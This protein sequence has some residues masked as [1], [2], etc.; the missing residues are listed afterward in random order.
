M[1]NRNNRQ[2]Y[3]SI[4]LPF[5]EREIAPILP[6]KVLDFHTHTWSREGRM[7]GPR[8]SKLPGMKYMVTDEEY[9]PEALLADGRTCFPDREYHAVCFGY[10]TPT[11][12]WEKD[13]AFIAAA[14]TRRG[15]YPLVLAG[16]DLGRS[17][18]QYEQAIADGN[19]LGFK[20]VLNWLGDDYG[21]KRVEDLLGPREMKL[22]NERR[23]VVMLHV[24][25]AGRLADPV[26]QRGVQR[27]SKAYPDA[28]IVLAHCGRCYLPT[29]MRAAIE[30][31]RRLPNVRMDTAMVMDQTAIRMALDTIGPERLLYATD[32]PVAAMRG[33]RVAVMDHW[34]DVVLPGYPKSAYRVADGS[35]RATFMAWEIVLAIRWAAELAGLKRKELNGI[36][37]ENG[38]AILRR[39]DGGKALARLRKR[40]RQQEKS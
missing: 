8:Q 11:V 12:D 35:I 9:P 28:Q 19:F 32:F 23:L 36:F 37:F 34:V 31:I 21:N 6:P 16:K 13:T 30:S 10:P 39:V 14:G 7:I 17:R 40:W 24:P 33:R 4:D 26:V 15:L 25:R 5:Y 1:S 18:A 27:L 22:A 3:E 29:E 38:M 2:R 20:V